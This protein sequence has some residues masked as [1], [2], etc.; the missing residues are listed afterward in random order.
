[1]SVPRRYKSSA[2]DQQAWIR[3]VSIA[4]DHKKLTGMAR[5]L[6]M[7]SAGLKFHAPSKQ[8]Y[9]YI[10]LGTSASETL[11]DAGYEGL[12]AALE[13]THP[14][15]LLSIDIMDTKQLKTPANAMRGARE[16]IARAKGG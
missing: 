3:W 2:K 7:H 13:V 12:K 15:F 4:L 8:E 1:M 14:G 9:Q 5:E 10:V 11:V 6:A 16:A